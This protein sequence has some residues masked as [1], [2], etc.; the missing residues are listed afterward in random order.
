MTADES[1]NVGIGTT[2]ISELYTGFGAQ[3]NKV[4]ELNYATATANSAPF[5][6]LSLVKNITGTSNLVGGITFS[7]SASGVAE[8][9]LAQIYAYTDGAVNSGSIR[10]STTNSG[11][12]GEVM[13]IDHSGNVGIGTT[14]PGEALEVNGN[15]ITTADGTLPHIVLDST[16]SGDNWTAQGAY[17][18]IG[19]NGA[20][21]SASM[22]LTYT[23]DGFGYS[24]AGTV[25]TG[26]PAGGYWRYAYNS[27]AI[28]TPASVSIGSLTLGGTAISATATEL[29]ILDGVTGLTAAELTNLGGITATATELN[30]VDGVTSAIQTQLGLKAPLA[31]PSFTG[32]ITSAGS[33]TFST[34]DTSISFGSD[35]RQMLNLYS[36][37]YGIGVQGSTGYFRSGGNF[38]FYEGGVHS[39]TA[40]APGTGGNARMVILSGGNVGI[41]TTSPRGRLEVV[42]GTANIDADPAKEF[43]VVGPNNAMGLESGNLQIATNDAVAQDMGGS[44][45]FGARYSGTSQANFAVIKAGLVGTYGG[46]LTLG[47]RPDGGVMTERIR[48]LSGGNVGIGTTGPLSKLSVG[49]VGVVN[50]GVYGT[51]TGYGVYGAG[52]SYGVYGTGTSYGM[53][54]V[55]GSTG[56]RADGDVYDFYA[57][58]AGTD[59]GTSS[60][61]RWKRN[62]QPIDNALGKVLN[63]SGVYYDWDADHGGKHDMGMIAEDV[64]KVIPEIVGWDSDAPGYATGMDYGHLTPVLVEAIKEQQKEIDSLKLVLNPAGAISNASSTLA[65][66]APSNLFGWLVDSLNTLGLVLKDGVASL[67]EVV[68]KSVTTEQMCVSSADGQK[69]CLDRS[70]LEELLKKVGASSTSVKTYE[71]VPGDNGASNSTSTAAMSVAT[72]TDTVDAATTTVADL[73]QGQVTQILDQIASETA[74]TSEETVP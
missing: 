74:S 37:A 22:H 15:I 33:A 70:Q 69:T 13:R 38:A 73:S 59:Y 42:S 16:S 56:I 71:P 21:G 47:T 54:A 48:I 67:R 36:T 24:G 23:G 1:G 18:S 30:Y 62:I 66:A 4:L 41:G 40:L 2:G 64:G 55:G 14:S 53:R 58:G 46:Y 10:F 43:T 52:T 3:G 68:A 5:P 8:L 35:V 34:A 11:T 65:T 17:I 26:I 49:G 44:I 19:E 39:D 63:L 61:I 27:Q 60:S 72:D 9:R 29:N 57:G 6:L 28:Y 20:L 25:A 32:T 7:N 50:A 51:G 12:S 45:A 31:S